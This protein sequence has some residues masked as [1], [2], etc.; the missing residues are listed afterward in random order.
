[1][2]KLTAILL[3]LAVV[4]SFAIAANTDDKK[5][6]I[7]DA[8][9]I[10]MYLA[11]M[12]SN[13]APGSTIDDALD[14]LIYLAGIGELPEKFTEITQPSIPEPSVSQVFVMSVPEE[15]FKTTI[16]KDIYASRNM[17]NDQS[18]SGSI[19]KLAEINE[20]YF[21]TI[22]IDG[23]ELVSVN[24]NEWRFFF[25]YKPINPGAEFLD[26]NGN[27]MFCYNSGIQVAISREKGWSPL[28]PGNSQM[29]GHIIKD[30]LAYSAFAG[31]GND[32]YGEIGDTWF[33]II[34]PEKLFTHDFARSLALDLISSA[35]LVN[36]DEEIGRLAQ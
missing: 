24:I 10:L 8:L 33:R 16:V 22:K 15:N 25:R 23:F 28:T 1:M 7:N 14:I 29:A 32:V 5:A 17:T 4:L 2:K 9:E 19:N 27:Y 21:P 34:M 31:F 26:R 35:E 13:A 6:T 18:Q 20:F 36:V 11:G 3:T 12:D 30:N